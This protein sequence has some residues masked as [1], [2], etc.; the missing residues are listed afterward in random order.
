MAF[1]VVVSWPINH[2]Q[3]ID[4][5]PDLLKSLKVTRRFRTPQIE[6]VAFDT[7]QE[8]LE[9]KARIEKH[10]PIQ[11]YFCIDHNDKPIFDQNG[12]HK[13]VSEP[14]ITIGRD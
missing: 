13:L 4:L 3:N 11:N 5:Y 7:E 14:Q 6:F 12:V 1:I 9:L 10:I 2:N 8:A